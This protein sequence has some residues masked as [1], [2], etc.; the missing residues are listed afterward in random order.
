MRK[1]FCMDI[2]QKI[3]QPESRKLEFKEKLPAGKNFLKTIAAFANGAGGELILGVSDEDRQI[4]GVDD[5]L[6]LEEQ[7]A[8]AIHDGI[9]PPVSPYFSV[10]T[11]AGKMLLSVQ[12]LSGGNK[13]YYLKSR[14]IEKGVFVRIGSTN[15][16]APLE[17]IHELQRQSR[18]FSYTAEIDFSHEASA[19]N[20]ESLDA[21]FQT[22]SRKKY[23]QEALL[24]WKILGR[25][26]GDIFPTVAGMVLFGNDSLT[27]YDYAHVRL[28]RFLGN[29]QEHILETKEYPLPLVTKIEGICNDISSFLRKE[30]ILDGI[31]RVEQTIIPFYALRE[32]VV[33]AIVHRDYSIKGSTIKLNVYD[34]R[35]EVI[36]PG[37]LVGNLDINDLGTGLSECRNRILV[38]IFR[39]LGLMEELGTGIARINSLYSKK[40][41]KQPIYQEQ[42]RFFKIILPQEKSIS[43]PADAVY[44]LLHSEG[45]MA[46][47]S[48][49]SRLGLHHNT[50]LK[51]LKKMMSD[52][53]IKKRGTGKNTVYCISQ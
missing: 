40:G 28:T 18:G 43:E 42:G 2:Q 17:T 38:R 45:P 31:R 51:Y 33:N 44:S 49:A 35:L 29:T 39:Q 32:A 41:L 26:N 14:G 25:N 1:V 52:G 21:F 8:S 48:L 16:Q 22:L 11:V 15:R 30:S 20:E 36:S 7:L 19:L 46:A 27:D 3:K 9:Y 34:D 50:I 24:K 10:I 12:V 13:P 47:S 53:K 23:N 6:L 37:V 5:P 4:K